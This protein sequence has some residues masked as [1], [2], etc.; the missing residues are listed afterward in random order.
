[1]TVLELYRAL[2]ARYPTS[3]SCSW[4]SDGLM[5]CPNPD[6]EVRQAVFALDVTAA[7]LTAALEAGAD[8]LITHHPMLFRPLKAVTPLTLNGQRTLAALAGGV[9][10]ISLHTRLDAA[11]G[12]VND[13]LAEKLGLAVSEK[14]GDE[15]SPTLGRIAV[16]PEAVSPADFARRVRDALGCPVQ[17]TGDRPVQRIAIVGGDG[18]DFIGPATAAGADTLVTGAASYNTALDAAESGLNVIEAGHYFTEAPVLERLAAQVT[19]LCGAK[20]MIVPSN[21]TSFVI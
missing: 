19:E 18:K 6:R 9:A 14:F 10:V 4:D 21:R 1:M 8:V 5:L 7:T 15:D 2:D 3:L 20:C 11:E 12:G 17:V 13:A 16:L